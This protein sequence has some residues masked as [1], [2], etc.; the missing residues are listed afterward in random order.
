MVSKE[1]SKISLSFFL[2][3][4]DTFPSDFVTG[5]LRLWFSVICMLCVRV[6][7]GFYPVNVD[8]A[9]WVCGLEWDFNLGGFSVVIASEASL[10]PFGWELARLRPFNMPAVLWMTFW[11]FRK[12]EAH[13]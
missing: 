9:S 13:R 11:E 3:R 4:K 10:I 12:R 2:C 5:S 8:L 6:D 7:L 1:K